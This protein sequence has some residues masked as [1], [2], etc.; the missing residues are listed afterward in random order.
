MGGDV[1]GEIHFL[2]ETT[3]GCPPWVDV[4]AKTAWATSNFGQ[5]P[6]RLTIHDLRGKE[7]SINLDTNA[8][9]VQK[10]EGVI[11]DGFDD[12]SDAQRIYY[13]E[14]I[15]FLKNH[16]GA[17][18]VIIFN[19]LFRSRGPP[20]T[21]DQ[22]DVNHKNPVF[23]PHV[24]LD[25]A[26]AQWKLKQLLGDEEAEK[27]MKNRFQIIN[28]WRPL[29]SEV[30]RNKPLAVCDYASID[31]DNDV[32]PLE[33]RGSLNALSAYT[34]SRNKQDAQR[35]L[36]LSDMQSNEMFLIKVFDSNPHVAQYC[37]HTAFVNEHVPESNVE[38]KSMEVR[39]LILYDN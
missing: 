37:F 24:D 26:G 13:D 17:S 9:E 35:W 18:R 33:V 10:Y 25:P 38:Q 7:T 34:I 11:S 5:V 21:D 39:C 27:A 23:Y 12:N 15:S 29:G 8:I 30:I 32:H 3:D 31:T 19:H 1:I 22:C 36:Y 28:I 2:T 16:L 6:A 4:N 20:R 14:L